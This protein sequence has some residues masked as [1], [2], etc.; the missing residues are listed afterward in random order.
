MEAHVTNPAR[1]TQADMQ[2]A[3][4]A[5]KAAGFKRA[6][7]IMNLE[8][9]TIEIIVEDCQTGSPKPVLNEWDRE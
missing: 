5:V 2:R 7:I 3:C 8:L 6:T 9:Q 4:N 1:I